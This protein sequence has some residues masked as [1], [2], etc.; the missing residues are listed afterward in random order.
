MPVYRALELKV[1]KC[2]LETFAHEFRSICDAAMTHSKSGPAQAVSL[3]LDHGNE[4][5]ASL[6]RASGA[7]TSG[8]PTSAA[9]SGVPEDPFWLAVLPDVTALLSLQVIDFT[10]LPAEMYLCKVHVFHKYLARLTSL[11]CG[12]VL[13]GMPRRGSRGCRIPLGPRVRREAEAQA[14]LLWRHWRG[15]I[16]AEEWEEKT[17]TTGRSALGLWAAACSC[18]GQCPARMDQ[19]RAQEQTAWCVKQIC[20]GK[21]PVLW[22]STQCN[23]SKGCL[24]ASG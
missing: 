16:R 3:L 5:I 9:D 20:M 21:E 8:A 22:I 13:V 11:M 7:P 1:G 6:E 17:E 23:I 24:Y 2:S 4:S 19:H 10:A 14:S 12:L 15:V 18:D